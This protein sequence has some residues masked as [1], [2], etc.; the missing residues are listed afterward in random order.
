MLLCKSSSAAPVLSII[1]AE[2]SVLLTP[3]DC[4]TVGQFGGQGMCKASMSGLPYKTITHLF[5]CFLVSWK[6]NDF[7][8]YG[9]N[10]T[11]MTNAVDSTPHAQLLKHSCCGR[12]YETACKVSYG[13]ETCPDPA[14]KAV[15]L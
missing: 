1:S 4:M 15:Q 2:D 11:F 5:K 7:S 6:G 8:C 13:L 9:N 10:L 14:L 12:G 3:R